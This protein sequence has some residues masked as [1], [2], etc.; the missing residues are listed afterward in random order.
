M[1]IDIEFNAILNVAEM[2]D[3][4]L[5]VSVIKRQP[6]MKFT[7]LKCLSYYSKQLFLI[8]RIILHYGIEVSD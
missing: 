1:W 4:N 7:I 3:N 5:L 8:V 6:I 2:I